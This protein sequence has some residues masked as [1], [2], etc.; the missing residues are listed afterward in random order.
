MKINEIISLCCKQDSEI[1]SMANEAIINNISAERYRVIVP[2]QDVELFKQ[3]TNPKYIV[4]PE[5]L[6]YKNFNFLLSSYLPL[7]KQLDFNWYFQQFIK[8]E[9]L[10]R[11]GPDETAVIWDGDTLPLRPIEF[12]T[13]SGK[14]KYFTGSEHHQPY[15]KT[16]RELLNLNKEVQYSFISQSFPIRSKWFQ[17]FKS[18]IESRSGKFWMRAILDSIDFSDSNAFSEYETLGTFIASKHQDEIV[19]TTEPWQRLGNSLIGDIN[20]L[21][22]INAKTKLAQ[23]IYVSFEKWDRAKPIFLKKTIPLFLTQTLKPLL[24]HTLKHSSN[25]INFRQIYDKNCLP[26][27]E[28]QASKSNQKSKKIFITYADEAFKPAQSFNTK[29]AL[30]V[31]NFNIVWE[32]GPDSL[33]QD[34][35]DQN[36]SI[37]KNKVGSGYW[38]WK[39]YIILDALNKSEPGDLIMYSD[40]AS[41]FIHSANTLFDLLDTHNQDIIPFELEFL[42]KEWTKRDAFLLCNINEDIIKDSRQRCGSPIII[43]N[44]DF[45]KSFFKEFLQISC[46]Q[47]AITDQ[48]NVLGKPNFS[49]FKNHRHDQSIFSLLTKK[50]GLS[51]FRD[52]SQWGNQFANYY[53]ESKYPQIVNL[54]RRRFPNRL[55]RLNLYWHYFL[56]Q[57]LRR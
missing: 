42:E 52:P 5:T 32:Y 16:I 48:P 24:T 54:T 4:D 47:R 43:R 26:S 20:L 2:D 36:K 18:A 53:K 23:F 39:P 50:H 57:V 19:F 1:W 6:F 30:I 40:S 7:N 34:F 55:H 11:L 22:T 46:D 28:S 14:L 37:L 44:S 31:G 3:I 25:I 15:F 12:I 56:S 38:L 13:E 21:N 10:N 35:V 33:A 27:T 45:S 49:N 41:Y 29:S 17:E 9:A 51:A 8:L